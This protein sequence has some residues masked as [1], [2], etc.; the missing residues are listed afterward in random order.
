M[1]HRDDEGLPEKGGDTYG[2]SI[3]YGAVNFKWNFLMETVML[4]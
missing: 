3:D 2:R 1:L 4:I